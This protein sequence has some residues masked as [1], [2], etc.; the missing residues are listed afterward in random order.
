MPTYDYQ[1][2]KCGGQ[3]SVYQTIGDYCR[4][5]IRPVCE[6]GNAGATGQFVEEATEME[7]RL[8][9]VAWMSGIANAL[10][11][12]RHYDGLQATDGTPINSRT[13]HR[14]YM[15]A[16]G[17]TMADDFKQTWKDA[18]KEREAVRTMKKGDPELRK[19][20]AEQV[21][22]AVAQPD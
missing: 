15:K 10:A 5:P 22:R 20:V 13:K 17:L 12:D 4:D 6:H 2:P 1:C 14:E 7:R 16:N 18:A 21:Y 11:G 8:S 19:E 9:V 3:T